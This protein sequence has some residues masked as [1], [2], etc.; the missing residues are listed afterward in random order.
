L[1]SDLF[2]PDGSAKHVAC[3]PVGLFLAGLELF[4]GVFTGEAQT[5][6]METHKAAIVFGYLPM[7]GDCARKADVQRPRS[8]SILASLQVRETA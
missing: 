7:P 8:T 3:E 1:I 5:A 4:A 6:R 2:G